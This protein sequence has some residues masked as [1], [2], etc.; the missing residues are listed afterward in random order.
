[1]QYGPGIGGRESGQTLLLVLANNHINSK[2]D[3]RV[4]ERAPEREQSWPVQSLS[5]GVGGGDPARSEVLL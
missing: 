1:M 3:N 2:V 5:R 4:K